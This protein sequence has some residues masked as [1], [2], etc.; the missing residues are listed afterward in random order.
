M[1]EPDNKVG[2]LAM[3]D[4]QL[5]KGYQQGL[6]HVQLNTS[7]YYKEIERRTQAKH[8]TAIRRLTWVTAFLGFIATVVAVLTLFSKFG[9]E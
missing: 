2:L 3:T 8:S 4:E 1:T 7:D 5:R 6:E 9:A